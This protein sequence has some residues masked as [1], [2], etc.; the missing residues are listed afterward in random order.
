MPSI[1]DRY[2]LDFLLRPRVVARLADA[3]MRPIVLLAAGA[4]W[5]KSVALDQYL[6]S[7]GHGYRRFDVARKEFAIANIDT[8]V[9]G[10]V[11]IDGLER[12]PA[13]VIAALVSVIERSKQQIQWVVATRSLV[14]LPV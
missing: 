2:A 6:Q 14:G 11:A 5:G 7:L 3:S 13:S 9:A 8:S 4:G 10:V 1:A 12:A